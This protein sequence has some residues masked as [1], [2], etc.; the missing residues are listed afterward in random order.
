MTLLSVLILA[1]LPLPLVDALQSRAPGGSRVEVESFSAPGCVATRFEAQPFEAS[2]RVAVRVTG[3]GCATWGW[4]TVRLFTT[5]AVVTKDVEAG[6]SL[7]GMT[8]IEEREWRPGTSLA[9]ALDGAMASRRLRAG[10]V[11][12]EMD[13]RFGPAPGTP[14]TVRVI[15][16]TIQIEQRGTVVPCSQQVC[17]TLPSGKRVSGTFRDGVLVTG[18][19]RGS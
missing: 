14:V 3:R 9:P 5:Q 15:V 4:A 2:G 1:S 11:L 13:V 8:R 7:E 16:N 19:E 17:A 12:R 10:T 6:A 18:L